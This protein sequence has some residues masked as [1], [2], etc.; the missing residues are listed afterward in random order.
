MRRLLAELRRRNVVRAGVAYLI[1]A[2]LITQ[3][4][5]AIAPILGLAPAFGKGVLLLLGLGFPVALLF[6]W[7]YELTPE[8]LKKTADVPEA[9]SI[10]A[11]TA[12]KLDYAILAG[13]ALVAAMFIFDRLSPQQPAA[14]PPTTAAAADSPEASIA[15]L[16]FADM[17]PGGDQEYF[18]DGMAEEILN[19]LSRI[20]GLKVAGRTSSFTFRDGSADLKA[21]GQALGVAHILEGS[22]RKQGEKVRITAQLIRASDGFHLWSQNYD[23]DLTDI[24]AVQDEIS[25]AIGEA[26]TVKIAARPAKASGQ[27]DPQAYDLYLRARQRLAGRGPEKIA[28]AGALFDAAVVLAPDF[29]GAW[30]GAARAYSLLPNYNGGIHVDYYIARSNEAAA[31][32]LALNPRNAEAH[33]VI[34]INTAGESFDLETAIE[35]TRLAIEYGPN[36]AEIANFAGDIYRQA[37]DFESAFK[38]ERR[39]LELDPLLPIN[40]VDLGFVYFAMR[41]CG[42]AAA[43]HEAALNLDPALA[44]AYYALALALACAGD[45]EGGRAAAAAGRKIEPD[46]ALL[47]D[48]EIGVAVAAN[49]LD[50]ARR[51]TAELKRRAD[52]GAE[53]HYLAAFRESQLGDYAAAAQSLMRAAETR[54]WNFVGDIYNFVPEDWPNDPAIRA[55]LDRAELNPLWEIRRKNLAHYPRAELQR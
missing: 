55:A 40:H 32:A 7:I 36:D 48:A 41:R 28:Q 25:R 22:V 23:R 20:E 3:V 8:G 30:S 49:R 10:S 54:D 9:Q 6:S 4:V 27:I 44:Q 45:F 46:G 53:I 12:R 47:I 37:A 38:W 11:K 24:F 50:E 13:V 43:A 52:G 17:S 2:W 34:A 21:I 31:R 39:A 19:V 15:V 26:L 5:A 14:A 16:P 1:G 18:A 42:E 51:L 29:D 33:S 35:E